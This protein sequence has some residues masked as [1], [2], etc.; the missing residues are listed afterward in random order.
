M[1]VFD[2]GWSIPEYKRLQGGKLRRNGERARHCWLCMSDNAS[3][4]AVRTTT[5][6]EVEGADAKQGGEGAEWKEMGPGGGIG[7]A[8]CRSS[9]F[10]VSG[11]PQISH[12]FVS[13][14]HKELRSDRPANRHRSVLD[15]FRGPDD[16]GEIYGSALKM[17]LG[18]GLCSIYWRPSTCMY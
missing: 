9:M 5:V 16:C 12:S 15:D 8:G 13:N 10:W 2:R 3:M 14:L 4:P 11:L 18:L 6:A 1:K 17:P 7:W